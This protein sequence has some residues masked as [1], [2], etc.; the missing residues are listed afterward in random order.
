M[1]DM[2]RPLLSYG[3]ERELEFEK[4]EGQGELSVQR[5]KIEIGSN[6][7]PVTG[8][9]TKI[10][11]H[12]NVLG[13]NVYGSVNKLFWGTYN[14]KLAC[15]LVVRFRFAAGS[16]LFRLRKAVVA[17]RFDN[18]PSA[19][20]SIDV[21]ADPVVRIF[22]PKHI[23]GIP[24]GVEHEHIWNVKAQCSVSIGPFSAGPEGEYGR[25]TR[26]DTESALEIAGMDEPDGDKELSNKVVFEVD[27]NKKTANGV[28]RELLFGAVVQCD[29][30][31]QAD[32]ETS[33]GDRTAWPWT[34]DD[35]IILRP[36]TTYGEI[37]TDMP[38]DFEQLTDEDWNTLVPY[39]R[40][41]TSA[42]QGRPE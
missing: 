14:N 3:E 16:R 37:S 27:E 11:Q 25:T 41:R 6:G 15:L 18:S 33:I 19:K 39:Q 17:F 13:V 26:Y 42:V 34:T 8:L 29:G 31:I 12:S 30:P 28:P 23:Y 1:P 36:G 9:R 21:Q 4:V 5:N 10:T 35:P 22:S 20:N 24:T 38:L 7:Q 32:V 40:E 2:E